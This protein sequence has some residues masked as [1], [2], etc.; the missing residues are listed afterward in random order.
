[1]TTRILIVED[2][3]NILISLEFILSQAGY[4]VTKSAD[5]ASAWEMLA[6]SPPDL[7]VMDVM[8]PGMDGFE[9]TR[10]MRADDRFKNVR[11]LMLSARGRTEEI[12]KGLALGANAYMTKP[13]ATRDL[14]QQVKSLLSD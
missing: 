8:V 13:F 2:D 10:R 11:I 6:E 9:L 7:V 5:G 1:M 3:H 4:A 12:E 14:L